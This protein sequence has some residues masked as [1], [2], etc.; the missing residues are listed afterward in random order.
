M[1]EV[2][3]PQGKR[4]N[5]SDWLALHEL[6]LNTCRQ[7]LDVMTSEVTGK[8]T[9]RNGSNLRHQELDPEAAWLKTVDAMRH[10]FSDQKSSIDDTFEKASRI[11][12]D[13]PY[14]SRK[15]LTLD[16]GP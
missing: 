13:R 2:G 6:D 14:E 4:H 8:P 12:V 1:N 10:V 3:D 11:L 15:A 5:L 7:I 16:N 9:A